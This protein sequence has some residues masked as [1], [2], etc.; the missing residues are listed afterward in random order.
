M[1]G[2]WGSDVFSTI[3]VLGGIAGILTS[4]N[5][6]LI[7]ASR[8]LYAMAECGML[9]ARLAKLHP[10]FNTPT[11]AILLVGALS[12][13]SPFFGEQALTW[14]VNGGGLGI[15]VAYLLVA[16][17]F[18]VLRRTEP[19][20]QRPFRA[21]RGPAIGIIAIVLSLGIATQY[22]PGMP[23][24]L[25]VP[26]WI[27][28]GLWA[29]AGAAFALRMDVPDTTPC[30][31]ERRRAD[32]GA[33][34]GC[35]LRSSPILLPWTTWSRRSAVQPMRSSPMSPWI[36]RTCS[37]HMRAAMRDPTVTLTW[38]STS[39]TRSVLQTG[40]HSAST[41]PGGS[42]TDRVSVPSR[43]PSCSTTRRCA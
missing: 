22:L 36:S 30:T 23:S 32:G 17:A 19:D 8:I 21:G 11:N 5:G 29:A 24:G 10:R 6:F 26:E 28:V 16:V 37:A 27:V 14:L 25:G 31:P 7:G 39:M 13:I 4:W 20:M 18:V 15:V 38:P 9:P 35:T 43:A 12:I 42:P 3:L 34:I 1:A 40:S 2:L 33:A 41:S